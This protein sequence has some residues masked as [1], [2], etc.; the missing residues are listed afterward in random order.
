MS[1]TFIQDVRAKANG[2]W[3]GILQQLGI[4]TNRQESECPNCGGNTRYRFDDK[5]G[6]G[7]YFCSHCGA[8]TGLD[9]VMKVN[10]CGARQAAE[11]VAAIL[12]LPLPV[13]KPTIE[14]SDNRTITERVNSLVA[15]A[16]SGQSDYL[17]NKGL[18]RPSLLLDEGSLLLVLQNMGG[19]PTGA[20]LIKPNGEKKLIAGSRKKGAF[21]P[22]NILPEHT[23]TVIIAE[24][25]ATAVTV[26]LLMQGVAISALDSGNLIHVAHSCREVWPD[27]K[28]ILAADNDNKP[29]GS[30]TGKIAAG[31]AAQAGNGMGS[32][33]KMVSQEVFSIYDRVKHY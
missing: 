12:A 6:R 33:L 14:K 2:H 17:L 8:G 9:L 21:I 24:G 27:A 15:K 28:I 4:P 23:D 32:L 5:E 10:K 25:Y 31:K 26:S 29:D 1:N 22:V 30:N 7:T 18:Q 3:E 19:T 20:Q 13:V 11:Q 16:V